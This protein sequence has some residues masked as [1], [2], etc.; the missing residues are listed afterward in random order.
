MN[1]ES[2]LV[3]DW[4]VELEDDTTRLPSKDYIRVV[5]THFCPY[6]EKE[7]ECH[8]AL[9]KCCA[10]H[11]KLLEL[12][13]DAADLSISSEVDLLRGPID[14]VFVQGC[15]PECCKVV[16]EYLGSLQTHIP[17]VISRPLRGRLQE[18]IQK[19]EIFFLSRICAEKGKQ[20]HKNDKKYDQL[21]E[22]AQ[23]TRK[24]LDF[25][26]EIALMSDFLMIEPLCDLCSAYLASLALSAKSGEQ[27]LQ[28]WEVEAPLT[29]KDLEVVYAQFP[30]LKKEE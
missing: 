8:F 30:F 22:I 24:S 27:L 14:P 2:V 3:S 12:P 26:L 25:L 11:C 6:T 9:Q 10:R 5:A 28:M 1:R 18:C 20:K 17:S 13:L 19:W 7:I 4:Y 29:E 21:P 15:T 16:F 23:H